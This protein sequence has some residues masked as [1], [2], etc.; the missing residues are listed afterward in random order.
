M[1]YDIVQ[2]I[3]IYNVM[4][5]IMGR[6]TAR[7]QYAYDDEEMYKLANITLNNI[8]KQDSLK[9][10]LMVYHITDDERYRLRDYIKSIEI[11]IYDD[12]TDWANKMDEFITDDIDLVGYQIT[13]Y[14]HKK[15]LSRRH[16]EDEFTI[17]NATVEQPFNVCIL[18]YLL[19][20]KVSIYYEDYVNG[21]P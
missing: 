19:K 6:F 2:Y 1:D 5:D 18:R 14:W 3:L 20:F 8:F 4:E 17:Y 11:Y 10:A 16:D 15:V 7:F 12:V 9:Y 21:Q 13:P